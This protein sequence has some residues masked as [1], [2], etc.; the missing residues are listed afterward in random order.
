MSGI[1]YEAMKQVIEELTPFAKKVGIKLDSLEERKCVLSLPFDATNGSPMGTLHAGPPFVLAELAG[2]SVLSAALD[3][4]KYQV[5]NKGVNIRFRRPCMGDIF[6]KM[7]IGPEE[8]AKIE[9][10]VEAAGKTDATVPVE[11]TDADGNVLVTAETIYSV[12]KM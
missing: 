7:E 6:A 12:R 11:I 1:T 8:V 10:D 5:I 3:L 9:A 4:S 2:A